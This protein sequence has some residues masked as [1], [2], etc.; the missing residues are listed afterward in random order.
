MAKDNRNKILMVCTSH[1]R[2]GETT[3]KTGFWFEEF[4]IPYYAFLDA[5]LQVD[6]ASPKGGNPPIDPSSQGASTRGPTVERFIKDN[7]S[8]AAL[9]ST[10]SLEMVKNAEQY[11][12]IFLVGG[13]GTMWDFVAN[14]ALTQLL[15]SAASQ[16]KVIGA[17]CH[18]VVGLL[19]SRFPGAIYGK[20]VTGFSNAEEEA[21]RK[22]ESVPFLLETRLGEAGFEYS[23]GPIFAPHVVTAG[24]LVTGQNPAS[25]KGTADAM[26]RML[27]EG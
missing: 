20:C 22:V 10:T 15:D 11:S 21:A 24:R 4:T 12:G 2:L 27:L 18:G 1:G 23:C 3:V 19:G 9:C 13:H 8:L 6:I 17:V 26:M 16:G 25:A 5:G 14:H 7:A